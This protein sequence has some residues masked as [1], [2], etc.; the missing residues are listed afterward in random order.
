MVPMVSMVP[1][2][3]TGMRRPS[4]RAQ[5]LDGHQ[6]GFDVARIVA[7]F[8]QQNVR[9]AIDQRLGLIVVILLQM[10]EGDGAG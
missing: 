6:P 7:G 5:L 9:A 1:E 2:T 4:S 8:E 3:I 10:V